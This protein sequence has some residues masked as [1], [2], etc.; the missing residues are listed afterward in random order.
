MKVRPT[1]DQLGHAVG[2]INRDSLNQAAGHV[3]PH[4]VIC[5]K[6][7]IVKDRSLKCQLFTLDLIDYSGTL[8]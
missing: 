2:E 3:P 7:T 8:I 1:M 6:K 5:L 4:F